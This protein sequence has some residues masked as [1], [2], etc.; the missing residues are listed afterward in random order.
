MSGPLTA[1]ETRDAIAAG[2][3]SA[4]EACRDALARMHAVNG[5]LNALT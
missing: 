4:V 3:L 2:R 1:I 5:V